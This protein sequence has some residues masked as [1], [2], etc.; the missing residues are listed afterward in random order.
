MKISRGIILIFECER[1][2]TWWQ[3]EMLSLYDISKPHI[4]IFINLAAL[5]FN[6]LVET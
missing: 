4:A 3:S 6:N 5:W 2:L 1:K